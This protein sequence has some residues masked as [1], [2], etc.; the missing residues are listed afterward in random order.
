MSD[1]SLL[2]LRNLPALL[3]IEH[4][5]IAL[6]HVPRVSPQLPSILEFFAA[7]CA[8]L[9]ALVAVLRL[10]MLQQFGSIFKR[11]CAALASESTLQMKAT[12]VT[13]QNLLFDCREGAN[14]ARKFG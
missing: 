10:L 5:A 14:V 3:A 2:I 1:M 6:M 12:H 8:F 7:N 11:K 9:I 4:D 13:E